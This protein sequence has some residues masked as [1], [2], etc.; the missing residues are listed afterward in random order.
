MG[1]EWRQRENFRSLTI[2]PSLYCRHLVP[3]F[4]GQNRLLLCPW[5]KIFSDRPSGTVRLLAGRHVGIFQ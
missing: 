2:S 3:T 5:R 4:K 1:F